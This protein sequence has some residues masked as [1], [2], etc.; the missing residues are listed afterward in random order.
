MLFR[1]ILYVD[2]YAVSYWWMGAVGYASFPF[3]EARFM[4][5]SGRIAAADSW[6]LLDGRRACGMSQSNWELCATH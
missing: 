2:M 4:L 5:G 3:A 6:L 1:V